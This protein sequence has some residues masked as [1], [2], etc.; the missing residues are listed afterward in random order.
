VVIVTEWDE[1]KSLDYNEIYNNMN[2]PAFL[3]DGRLLLDHQKLQKIGFVV[4]CVGKSLNM[5]GNK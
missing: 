3:F 1:F 2:K 5:L 4:E